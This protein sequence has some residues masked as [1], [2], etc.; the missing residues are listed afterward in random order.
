VEAAERLQHEA[1]TFINKFE[2]ADNVDMGLVMSEYEAYYEMRFD[3]KPK[4]VRKLKEGEENT[5]PGGRPPRQPDASPSS[6]SATNKS[7]RASNGG[8]LPTV[9]GAVS[10][11][12][13]DDD[14]ANGM[15]GLG[16]SGVGVGGSSVDN[17][18]G[19]G[20]KDEAVERFEER[21]LKPPPQFAGDPE[22]RTL[23]AVISR[24]IYQESPNVRFDDIVQLD[25]AK[26][27]LCEA[28]QLPLQYP[29]LFTGLLRPWK[30]ILV[31][32]GSAFKTYPN[33]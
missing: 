22:M 31:S 14:G 26:R 23:A 4:L 21:V 32:G 15:T 33:L 25:E 11:T 20:K 3:K 7:A 17:V 30:G 8:K 28:V 9:T 29:S 27:L 5:R 13:S 10:S 6:R 12:A 2:V 18:P 24:E 16:V 19:K 1:G